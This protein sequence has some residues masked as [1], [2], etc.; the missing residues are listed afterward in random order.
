MIFNWEYYINYHSDLIGNTSNNWNYKSALN[1][2]NKFGKNEKR[3]Y[4]DICIFFN[5]KEY[6]E[7]NKDLTNITKEEEA[8]KHFLYHG[9]TEN[10]KIK[11]WD[12]LKEY[13]V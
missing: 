1:H 4:T 10:R 11:Y 9:K 6:I 2:F 5:W 12:I 7:Q 8:W 13:C 3:I